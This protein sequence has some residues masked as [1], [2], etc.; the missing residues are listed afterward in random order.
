MQGYYQYDKHATLSIDNHKNEASKRS[1]LKSKQKNEVP[2]FCSSRNVKQEFNHDNDMNIEEEEPRLQRL[3]LL[4]N[5]K[6]NNDNSNGNGLNVKQIVGNG[7][8]TSISTQTIL[9]HLIDMI[10]FTV[11]VTVRVTLIVPPLAVK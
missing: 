4:N 6:N 7:Y 2:R 11:V 3:T 1:K 9:F 10:I 8:V 5:D